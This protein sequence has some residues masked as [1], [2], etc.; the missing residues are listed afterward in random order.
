M[1]YVL[2]TLRRIIEVGAMHH[3]LTV[4][5]KFEVRLHLHLA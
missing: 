3:V 2:D 1:D 5:D 4:S